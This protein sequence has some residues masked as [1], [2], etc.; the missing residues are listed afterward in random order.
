MKETYI[1][2]IGV[3]S[4]T[5]LD[6]IDIAYIKIHQNI[7][8]DFKILKAETISYNSY[9][10]EK[11]QEAI[12]YNAAD[13]EELDIEYGKFL[14]QVIHNFITK[15]TVSRLDFIASH[16]HTV[17][18]QPELGVTLQVGNGQEIANITKKEV[19]CDFRTQDVALGGQGAPLVPIGDKLLFADYDYCLN[20]GGFAN[21]SYEKNNKRIAFDICPVNIVLNHYTRKLG[22][23]F[24]EGGKIASKGKINDAL[25]ESLNSLNFYA[26]E[27]P[28]SLGLEWVK[29]HVFP[30]IDRKETDISTIL[31]TFVE[32]SAMQIAKIITKKSKILVTGGG[33][34]N[35][36]LMDRI[37]FYLKKP[38]P[39]VTREL[40][41]YKEALVFAFLGLLK[42]K[43]EV[44]CLQSVT[45]AKENHSSGKF[46]YPQK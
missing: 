34:F 3:M 32:H 17:L 13:L 30:L 37:A 14:G 11:L 29:E 16:G 7:Y 18:H 15:H 35:S 8:K 46:F 25:L 24:D 28:K 38:I 45:G 42:R 26:T 39:L 33:A 4:G 21:I 44:N 9:W 40:I 41:D 20:L 22:L 5:S 27:P 43:G 2:G 6:G 10:K 12:N 1:Y 23:D 19:V 31:R 36:F